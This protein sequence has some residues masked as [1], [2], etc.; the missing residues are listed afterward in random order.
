MRNAE[1]FAEN[2]SHA[3]GAEEQTRAE[4]AERANSFFR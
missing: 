1:S 3:V 2:P 4:T